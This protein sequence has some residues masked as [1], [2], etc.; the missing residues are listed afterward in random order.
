MY[1]FCGVKILILIQKV[2]F[3]IPI[4]HFAFSLQDLPILQEAGH[5]SGMLPQG[6]TSDQTVPYPTHNLVFANGVLKTWDGQ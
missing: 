4:S 3:C 1:V 6:S 5:E 2:N